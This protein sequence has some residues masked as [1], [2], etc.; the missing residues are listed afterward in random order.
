MIT[1]FSQKIKVSTYE[2]LRGVILSKNEFQLDNGNYIF[3]VEY[4]D[5][6]SLGKFIVKNM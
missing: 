2:Q 3:S 5:K 4:K 1:I 6:V